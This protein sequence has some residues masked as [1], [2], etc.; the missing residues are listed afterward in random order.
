[1]NEYFSLERETKEKNIFV[2]SIVLTGWEHC[3][4][5]INGGFPG[6]RFTVV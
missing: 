1:M 5:W 6:E 4:I 2:I 3:Y